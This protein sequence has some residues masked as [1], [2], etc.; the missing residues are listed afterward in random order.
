MLQATASAR[1][2]SLRATLDSVFA[3]PAYRWE[4]REDPFGAL[5]RLWLATGEYLARLREQN[6]AAFRTLTWLLVAVLAAILAHAVWVAVRT[7][8]GGSR[9]LQAETGGPLPAPRDAAWY[10]GEAARLAQAGDFVAA[11]QADFLR[12]ILELDAR[13]VV[14]FHPS[15]T[16]SEYARDAT[17]GADGRRA[18][19]ALVREMYAHAFAR[20]PCDRAAYDA[21]RARAMAE[22]YAPAN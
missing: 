7:V 10:A 6:P 21:W 3:S 17:L 15:K 13:R 18:L 12:F 22:R 20:V 5:R 8:R 16:P 11:M 9:R 1:A 19:G 2:D 14:A 4:T